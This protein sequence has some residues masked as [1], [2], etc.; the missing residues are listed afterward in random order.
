MVIEPIV[1]ARRPTSSDEIWRESLPARAGMVKDVRPL[2]GHV[3]RSLNRISGKRG[4]GERASYLHNRRWIKRV[5]GRGHNI[6]DIG[7]G[8]T[9]RNGL[10]YGMEQHYTRGYWNLRVRY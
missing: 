5:M 8:G 2:N 7:R 9:P 10:Y 6:V 1:L 4:W 3:C